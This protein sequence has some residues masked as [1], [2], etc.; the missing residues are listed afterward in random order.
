M[1]TLNC[2]S[3]F[4]FFTKVTETAASDKAVTPLG[5][6]TQTSFRLDEALSRSN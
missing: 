2:F 5:T 3:R 6:P 1:S 4:F